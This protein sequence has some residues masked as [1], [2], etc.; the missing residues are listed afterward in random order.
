MAQALGIVLTSWVVSRTSNLGWAL[1]ACHRFA[2][3]VDAASFAEV[4]WAMIS[5]FPRSHPH[6]MLMLALLLVLLIAL[7][8]YI[9]HY[10]SD[11]QTDPAK[12]P[13]FAGMNLVPT[14]RSPRVRKR[15][16]NIERI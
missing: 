4:V 14:W 9:F 8:G 1:L 12:R 5:S 2:S 7:W 11:R 15:T 16:A 10:F 6:P 3:T 13:C